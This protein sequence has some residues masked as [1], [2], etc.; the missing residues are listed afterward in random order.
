MRVRRRN[1]ENITRV[2]IDTTKFRD[3]GNICSS[4]FQSPLTTLV[5]QTDITGSRS[6]ALVECSCP[7]RL[8]NK[9]TIFQIIQSTQKTMLD[10]HKIATG[11]IF[12]NS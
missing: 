6:V 8:T 11:T 10:A 7:F 5:S 4:Q 12:Q 9:Q 1:Y 3:Y 2:S